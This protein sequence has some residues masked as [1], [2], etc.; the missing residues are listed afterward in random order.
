MPEV[1]PDERRRDFVSRC[2]PIVLKDKTAKNQKQ[3]IAI[4][5]S[6]FN[7]AQKKR[8]KRSENKYALLMAA[9]R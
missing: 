7:E 3:A 9:R 4:C 1:K 8:Q 6:M 2:I 5:F